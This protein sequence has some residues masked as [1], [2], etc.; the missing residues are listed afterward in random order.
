MMCNCVAEMNALLAEHN[1]LIDSNLFGESGK[2][3]VI[4]T[5]KA[6]NAKRGRPKKVISS[7]CPFCGVPKIDDHPLPTNR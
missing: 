5:C 7:F 2:H 4:S 1:T 6:D 3:V